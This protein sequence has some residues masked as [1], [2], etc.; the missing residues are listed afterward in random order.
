M[1]RI[2]A[3]SLLVCPP[4]SLPAAEPGADARARAVAPF[5]D[6]QTI[7]VARL[8]LE[9]LDPAAAATWVRKAGRLSAEQSQDLEEAL[10][11]AAL[12]QRLG[13]LTG[14]GARDLYLVFSLSD[15]P[16]VPCV[17]MPVPEGA[18]AG[19][20]RDQLGKTLHQDRPGWQVA[21]QNNAV[22]GGSERALKRLKGLRPVVRPEAAEAFA[23]AGNATIQF[24]FLPTADVRRVFRELAPTLPPA[25]G[26]G[27]TR[28][29]TDGL[30]W[31][32]LGADL[33]PRQSLRM[34]LQ[35]TDAMAA[36][37]LQALLTGVAQSVG[38]QPRVRRLLPEFDKLGRLLTSQVKGDRV[39]LSL[40]GKAWEAEMPQ[41][42]THLMKWPAQYPVSENMTKILLAMHNYHDSYGHFPAVANF[43]KDGKPL[44][45]WRVHLLPFLGHHDL[46]KEFRLDEPWDSEHNQKLLPRMPDLYRSFSARLNRAG[47][48]VVVLPV[49]PQTAFPGGPKALRISDFTDGTSGTVLVVTADDAHA[50]PWTKP[51]DLNFD[52]ER[53]NAGLA[54][55]SGGYLVGMADGVVSFLSVTVDPKK[56]L[57]VFTPGGGE[58]INRREIFAS[59]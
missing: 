28:P 38:R 41:L 40:S 51:E 20:V 30:R 14:A 24:L 33:P 4:A 2:A 3:L 15:V 5:L 56:L 10:D 50:V 32:A 31:A 42:I 37:E 26:G 52:P 7:A 53:P 54:H 59:E 18:D 46:F 43:G 29:L 16:R 48:T 55:Y 19:K 6:E 13:Q 27:S 22:V 44:L 58:V 11:L 36:R 57:P 23:A 45:S 1:Y 49:G 21:V 34:I 12:R 35:A 39:V 9:R 25:L 17:V 8:N 47:K